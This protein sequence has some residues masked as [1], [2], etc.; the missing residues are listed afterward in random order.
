M[1]INILTSALVCSGENQLQPVDIY[2]NNTV[3]EVRPRT[4]RTV[5]W[6]DIRTRN[7][8]RRLIA[9]LPDSEYPSGARLFDAGGLLVIPG[10][11][12]AH[13]HFN[14]PGFEQ[15]EDF[16]HGSTAA[17][18]GGVT[19]VIDMPCTSMPPVTSTSNQLVKLAALENRSTV[20]FALWGG[21]SGKEMND[22]AM[23]HQNIRGLMAH[24]VVGFKAYFISGM[25]SFTDLTMDQMHHAAEQ[26]APTGLPLAVHAEDK[27]L[28]SEREK[29]LRNL[30]RNTWRD[31]CA[32]RDVKAEV[33]AV[34]GAI[35]VAAATG[36]RL[37]I[38]HLSSAKGLDL[39]RAAQTAG[40][41]VS[42]E[43][44]PHYL[45][46]TQRDFTDPAISAFLKTAPPVKQARDRKALWQGLADGSLAF[47]TTDHAGCD[48][49]KEKTGDNFWQIY[50][51]IPGVEH[52]VPFMFSEGFLKGRLTLQRTIEV[53]STA[54][55]EF[56]NIDHRKGSLLSSRD[57]DLAVIDL[58]NSCV[59]SPDDMHSKGK[60]SPF[61]GKKFTGVVHQV[62]L[63][64]HQ[65]MNQAG[66]VNPDF[67]LGRWL[68]PRLH[69]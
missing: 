55:A 47:V 8:W 38:V 59:V 9:D 20:D 16:E 57:A 31:Y 56:F 4:D 7:N 26:I 52:R 32:S 13:V 41:K 33:A 10:A 61:A 60:Y 53:L 25:N 28:V 29:K 36:C 15:R 48:P 27:Q 64:G 65:L 18:S 30:D 24:R 1:A 67:S 45:H 22:P 21:V 68:R 46:F 2:F 3:R 14:T 5:F 11:I 23:V 69:K 51:G 54:P 39:V 58:W 42:A 43:T 34:A 37:H 49:T 50:G 66:N 44:C 62:F 63:R 19:T 6:H 12:D 35:E 40:L 17:L